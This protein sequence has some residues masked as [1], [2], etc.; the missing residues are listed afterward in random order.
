MLSCSRLHIEG[1]CVE[2][3]VGLRLETLSNGVRKVT[4]APAL[5]LLFGGGGQGA[6]FR[7]TQVRLRSETRGATGSSIHHQRHH[8]GH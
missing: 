1:V 3:D 2:L 7:A 5:L 4:D 6:C 8:C